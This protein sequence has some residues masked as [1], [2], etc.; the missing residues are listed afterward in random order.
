MDQINY[1][2]QKT[3]HIKHKK[4]IAHVMYINTQI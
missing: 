2:Q 3:I 1:T 4:T